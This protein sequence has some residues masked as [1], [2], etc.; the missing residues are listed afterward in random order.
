MF[1][2]LGPQLLYLSLILGHRLLLI[3]HR[4]GGMLGKVKVRLDQRS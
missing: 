1:G 2:E 4:S 3:G